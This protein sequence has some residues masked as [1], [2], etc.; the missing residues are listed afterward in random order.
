M[1]GAKESPTQY[2]MQLAK[3]KVRLQKELCTTVLS[4]HDAGILPM[5]DSEA[6]VVRAMKKSNKPLKDTHLA[7]LRA[8]V[9]RAN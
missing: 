7:V 2:S 9:E 1:P 5:T 8:L 6:A 4:A 3:G